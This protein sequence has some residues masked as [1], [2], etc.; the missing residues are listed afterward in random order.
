MAEGCVTDMHDA[1]APPCG[2]ASQNDVTAL[3]AAMREQ[4]DDLD[5]DERTFLVHCMQQLCHMSS[6]TDET[7][8]G[9]R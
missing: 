7:D 2:G 5:G 4:W 8:E 6:R 3:V 1:G 9:G